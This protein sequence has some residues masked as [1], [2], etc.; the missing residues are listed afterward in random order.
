[1]KQRDKKKIISDCL[2][3]YIN[4]LHNHDIFKNIIKAMELMSNANQNGNKA[5]FFGNGASAAIAS[6]AAL[7]FKKQAKINTMSLNDP[8]IITAYANDYG[9][10]NWIQSAVESYCLKGD[11]VV[12]ISSSGQ[13]ANILNAAKYV[14][15]KKENALITF[16][17]FS[18]N[19]P[20]RQ[21][22]EVNFWVDSKG[23]NIVE[24]VHQIW[25]ML[26]CDLIVGK[27]EY[28]VCQRKT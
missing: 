15:E 11:V 21:C 19:N 25:L 18:I 20:L 7:D 14:H 2:D 1:M 23:Y 6:H 22:G 24:C 28:S 13:S 4:I 3:Q 12:L 17:G 10:E 16:S 26:I 8:T 9:Y 27:L 5:I